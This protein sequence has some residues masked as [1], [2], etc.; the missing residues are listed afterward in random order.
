[1]NTYTFKN[2]EYEVKIK[3]L[4]E[5][6]H[7]FNK[8]SSYE[9][10]LFS[11]EDLNTYG[12][13]V[14]DDDSYSSIMLEVTIT[15][16]QDIDSNVLSA[17]LNF[18]LTSAYDIYSWPNAG[19]SN[20]E[21]ETYRDDC[22]P[23]SFSL[24]TKSIYPDIIYYPST[25]RIED[26]KKII[27]I[28]DV[29]SSQTYDG[30]KCT[31]S[32]ITFPEQL[33]SIRNFPFV[34]KITVSLSVTNNTIKLKN[35]TDNE[36][37]FAILNS[38][39]APPLIIYGK[40]TY[41]TPYSDV[42][43]DW[44]SSELQLDPMVGSIFF[45]Q[46]QAKFIKNYS[47]EDIAECYFTLREINNDDSYYYYRSYII[48]TAKDFFDIS[49]THDSSY[50]SYC[51]LNVKDGLADFKATYFSSEE[52]I[53][54]F[55]LERAELAKHIFSSELT[56]E[57]ISD[58]M[59][60]L[61]G[62]IQKFGPYYGEGELPF[63]DFGEEKN[64]SDYDITLTM[65]LVTNRSDPWLLRDTG[66]SNQ[67]VTVIGANGSL[68][69]YTDRYLDYGNFNVRPVIVLN[70][71]DTSSLLY[72]EKYIKFGHYGIYNAPI[73]WQCVHE[74]TDSKVFITKYNIDCQPFK[75]N[76]NSTQQIVSWK[77]S[78]IRSWLNNDFINNA[79]TSAEQELIQTTIIDESTDLDQVKIYLLSS[80]EA[81]SAADYNLN[82]DDDRKGY[83]TVTAKN[84]SS[85]TTAK[86]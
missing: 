39:N 35:I 40:N 85:S 41:F 25:E 34:G 82:S 23:C 52:E 18:D 83:S 66:A 46:F 17:Y 42:S 54:S 73:T 64:Y 58:S 32:F 84:N 8:P 75:R 45:G 30:T 12:A 1:M 19:T 10:Q 49:R 2:G 48:G 86:S 67:Y 68:T 72:D 22:W 24:T 79:F 44:S 26:G 27:T 16:P 80:N 77:D 13:M 38:V 33:E 47:I 62:H 71:S 78:D 36:D 51:G 28:G 31:L 63:P 11:A 55:R 69:T 3:D 76:V 20:Y 56:S 60:A 7:F 4:N 70:N 61:F 21:D 9:T 53:Q 50:M 37:Y 5:S 74:D 29:S 65:K 14:M 81:V 59:Y 57:E 15:M 6:F 43:L